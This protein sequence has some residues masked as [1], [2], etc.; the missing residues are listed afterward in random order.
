MFGEKMDFRA[1]TTVIAVLV[2]AGVFLGY[3]YVNASSKGTSTIV[4]RYDM[5]E[6]VRACDAATV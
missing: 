2:V 5:E 6:G 3:V 1:K 4:V